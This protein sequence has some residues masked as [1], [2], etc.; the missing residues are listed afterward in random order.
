MFYRV[1][2]EDRARRLSIGDAAL[3]RERYISHDRSLLQG[4]T[5][6]SNYLATYDEL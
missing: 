4:S 5:I 2:D 1:E 6:H 3:E